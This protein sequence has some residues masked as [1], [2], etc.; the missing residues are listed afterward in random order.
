MFL[1][2]NLEILCGQPD[3][4]VPKRDINKRSVLSP[5]RLFKDIR[6]VSGMAGRAEN[7]MR[8]RVVDRGE[9]AGYIDAGDICAER[10]AGE[11]SNKRPS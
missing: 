4:L 10:G 6:N 1:G 2:V 5:G 9:R 8:R 7:P 3:G 11:G